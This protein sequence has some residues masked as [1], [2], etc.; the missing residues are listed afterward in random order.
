[1][2]LNDLLNLIDEHLERERTT[3]IIFR[4]IYTFHFNDDSIVEVYVMR[5]STWLCEIVQIL[6]SH[7][8]THTQM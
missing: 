6:A 2:Q 1:V 5:S 3:D 8:Y 7:I 4:G